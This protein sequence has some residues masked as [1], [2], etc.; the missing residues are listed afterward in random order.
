MKQSKC[1]GKDISYALQLM[2]SG[3][4]RFVLRGQPTTVWKKK[5]NCPYYEYGSKLPKSNIKAGGFFS[6]VLTRKT[7]L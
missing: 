5:F 6:K 2:Q 4:H 7:V 1:C 3:F